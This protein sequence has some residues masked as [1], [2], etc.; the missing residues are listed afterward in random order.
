MT[1]TKLLAFRLALAAGLMATCAVGQGPASPAD[2]LAIVRQACGLRDG[3]GALVGGGSDYKVAFDEHGTVF[4]PALGRRASR[5][6]PFR[7]ALESIHRGGDV[8]TTDA[9]ADP[10]REGNTAVYDRA[11]GVSERW[12]VRP[13]GVEL[14][15]HFDRR[16]D[17]AGDLVVRLAVDTDLV[18]RARGERPQGL[19]F[20]AEGI[21]GVC[22]GAVTAIAADGRTAPGTLR[23]A[24]AHL[25][26]V[27]AGSFVDSATYPL[28][29]DPLIGA[30]I[31]VT[32]G[33]FDDIDPDVAYDSSNDVYLVCW[34][35]EFSVA[36]ADVQA[37][38][39]GSNGKLVGPLL[40][41]RSPG[42]GL[43]IN[44]TVAN[45]NLS[46][47]FLVAWQ[48][49]PSF[50]GP[51]N[52][53]GACVDAT[54]GA[55]STAVS[56]AA[57]GLRDEID[58]DA[59][60]EATTLDDEALLVWDDEGN[61]YGAPVTCP[62]GSGPPIPSSAVQVSTGGP[63]KHLPAISKNGGSS[64]RHL[65]A[66]VHGESVN[67][68]NIWGIEVTV[69]D[70][71]MN[72]L[73]QALLSQWSVP[74][75]VI[76]PDVDGDGTR[77]VVVWDEYEPSTLYSRDVYCERIDFDAVTATL[78]TAVP[79]VAVAVD[80]GEDERAPAVGFLGP[81]VVVAW[82]QNSAGASSPFDH[83]VVVRAL[84]L[85]CS[86]CGPEQVIGTGGRP[87][88]QDPQIATAMSG[89]ASGD[90]AFIAF[91]SADVLPPYASEVRGHLFAALGAGGT[92]APVASACGNGGRV[93]A[94]SAFAIGNPSLAFTLSGADP[95]AVLAVWSLALP[96]GPTFACGTCRQ[97]MVPL[98]Q[99]LVPAS[100]GAASIPVPMPCVLSLVGQT[101]H[102][103][104]W[105]SPANAAPCLVG[106]NKVAFS[107]VVA[108]TV[109][110]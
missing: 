22:V 2:S 65:V 66:Y 56:I 30:E 3:G 102:V 85:G 80:P 106:P 64:G 48:E 97:V 89:G 9:A 78:Q 37:Q 87:Y 83:D 50:F 32:S 10:R 8:W 84:D 12:E 31:L 110:L 90:Q 23:F 47:R 60:S 20:I 28:V 98:Y 92:L 62:A 52:V 51:W 34:Q 94:N 4:V 7:L 79:Q 109:G 43:A 41:V 45:V 19:H 57:N 39:V 76:E 18:A 82:A 13:D 15:F 75:R 104:W 68:G 5:T 59:S 1:M 21:G 72:I 36:D 81:K 77:F 88:D 38:R 71:D 17:G 35:R 6:Y 99:A 46:D 101:L 16:P 61:I 44:P 42:I 63:D 105:V 53:L 69:V 33:G 103:Q 40:S 24:D 107:N 96:G 27:V 91:A 74:S 73:D 55:V 58:P 49:G 95:I 54:T 100:G 26:L 29:L 70:K 108:A 67:A 25:E 11:P 86:V 14:S 93:G